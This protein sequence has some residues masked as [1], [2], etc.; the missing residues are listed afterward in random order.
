[1]R[2]RETSKKRKTGSE[3]EGARREGERAKREEEG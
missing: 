2:S 3:R 1:M